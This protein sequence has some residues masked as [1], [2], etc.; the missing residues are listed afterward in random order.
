MWKDSLFCQTII[1][2]CIVSFSGV[3]VQ[4]LHVFWKFWYPYMY[5]VLVEMLTIAA[6]ITATEKLRAVLKA[7]PASRYFC[8]RHSKS[9]CYDVVSCVKPAFSAFWRRNKH[10][11]VGRRC[12]TSGV[13]FWTVDHLSAWC[14]KKYIKHLI[15]LWG[16]FWSVLIWSKRIKMPHHPDGAKG[17][18]SRLPAVNVRGKGECAAPKRSCG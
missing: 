8:V 1:F 16:I 2:L 10:V 9:L 5:V 14:F 11:A 3:A 18:C 6:M 15:F 12:W 13:S 7:V 17:S 4:V